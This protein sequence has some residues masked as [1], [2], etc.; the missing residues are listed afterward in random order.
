MLDVARAG[1]AGGF[2]AALR[3]PNVTLRVTDEQA[4]K[5]AFASDNGKV[6]IVLAAAGRTP[7]AT[8][9]DIVTLETAALRRRAGGGREVVRRRAMSSDPG[10]SS[11]STRA[12][13]TKRF[14]RRCPSTPEI[15]IVGLVD[16][17]EDSWATLQETP[18]DLLVVACAGYSD[19]ALYLIDGAVK[20]RPDRPVV[21]LCDGLAERVR[22]AGSSRPARTTS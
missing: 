19:R 11:P 4:A 21:V 18:T 9:P 16:G 12:S 15:Q 20:Q 2:G 17:L 8:T 3:R 13:T 6:W 14:R 10:R 22:A 5:L 7:K 1:K